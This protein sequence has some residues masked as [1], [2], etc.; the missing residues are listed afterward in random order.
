MAEGP[1]QTH[2]PEASPKTPGESLALLFMRRFNRGVHFALSV[3]LVI[4]SLMVVI[5][6]VADVIAAFTNKTLISGFLHALG[7]LLILWTFSELLNSE[8]RYL[9]GGKIEVAV[10]IEVAIAATIRHALISTAEPVDV[11]SSLMT[12]GR[13]LTL[14][15][16]YWLMSTGARRGGGAG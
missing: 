2:S 12:L 11:P 15:A 4:A 7:S 16:V 14:G 1:I 13:L 9:R 3:S 6:F 8:V 10:F 5:L